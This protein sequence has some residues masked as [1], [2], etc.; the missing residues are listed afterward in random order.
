MTTKKFE[1]LRVKSLIAKSLVSIEECNIPCIHLK[2]SNNLLD[3]DIDLVVEKEHITK[4]ALLIKSS[5]ENLGAVEVFSVRRDCH[6]HLF[7]AFLDGVGEVIHIDLQSGIDWN[8]KVLLSA[9]KI[10]TQCEYS[11]GSYKLSNSMLIALKVIRSILKGT[12][13]EQYWREAKEGALAD[14]N[15]LRNSLTV[16]LGRELGANV[17]SY[18][19]N[20]DHL[21]VLS[22]KSEIL[23][24]FGI[25]QSSNF[26]SKS[27]KFL[28]KLKRLSTKKGVYIELPPMGDGKSQDVKTALE[29][30]LSNMP[31]KFK[32][33]RKPA[34]NSKKYLLYKFQRVLNDRLNIINVTFSTQ[35]VSN[36]ESSIEYSK[37]VLIKALAYNQKSRRPSLHMPDK[38]RSERSLNKNITFVGLDGA[39]K[40]TYISLLKE[41]L[42]EIGIPYNSI[43]L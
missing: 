31:V 21:G 1:M 25:H 16:F 10:L 39:G 2:W 6:I 15:M 8:Q 17:F 5:A 3:G 19:Y 23:H 37:G 11:D 4:A 27:T 18:L 35:N 22:I 14:S 7:F 9:D 33:S 20:G 40:G 13:K 34:S 41:K 30:L 24:Y 26:K 29:A 36:A 28:N 43:Y 38:V 12:F 32:V 42:V